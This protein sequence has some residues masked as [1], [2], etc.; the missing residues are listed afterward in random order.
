M[1]EGVPFARAFQLETDETPDESASRAWA[2]YRHWT[3][4]VSVATSGAAVWG[5][6]LAIAF[7]AFIVRARRRAL[8]RQRWDDEDAADVWSD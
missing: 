4:W 2:G 5:L 7:V 8:Q 6:I 1:A 3:T